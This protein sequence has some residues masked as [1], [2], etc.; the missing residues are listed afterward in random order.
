MKCIFALLLIFISLLNSGTVISQMK[1]VSFSQ[2]D[3][4]QKVNRRNVVIF[5]HTDWCK[6]CQSMK[7]TTFKNDQIIQRLNEHFYFTTLNAEDNQ[8]IYFNG[9]QFHYKP[10]GVNTGINELAEAL[11][12]IDGILNY[13]AMV[14]LNPAYEI[15]FQS[16][17]F[18]SAANLLTILN[19]EEK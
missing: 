8:T 15:I 17:Q 6:Y 19:I 7:N 10:T 3:S 11:G 1:Q 13:P 16:H 5:I 9:Q 18:L 4:L 2:I 14:I 12:S